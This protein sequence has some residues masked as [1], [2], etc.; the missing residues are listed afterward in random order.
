MT[1]FKMH[2]L[3]GKGSKIACGRNHTNSHMAT[4]WSEFKD[5]DHQCEACAKSRVAEL[6]KKSDV[7][8]EQ[9]ELDQWVPE[10]ADEWMKRDDAVVAAHKAK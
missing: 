2:L 10:A 6:N 3:T 7:K 1:H 4:K 8:K 5:S 9:E